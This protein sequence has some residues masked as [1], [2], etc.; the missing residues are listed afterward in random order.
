MPADTIHTPPTLELPNLDCMPANELRAF[1]NEW[2]VAN[3]AKA[4]ALVGVR[5]NA[6]K[7]AHTLASYAINKAVA[8]QARSQGLITTAQRYEGYC[9]NLY[10]ELPEDLRW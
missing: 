4:V 1:W 5:K 6:P 9:D 8:V 7:L 2:H 3:R 10:K